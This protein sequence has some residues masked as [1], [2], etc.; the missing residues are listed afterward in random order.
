MSNLTNNQNRV[1]L[2]LELYSKGRKIRSLSKE[3]NHD[4]VLKIFILSRLNKRTM[5]ISQLSEEIY[6]KLST[7]SETIELLHKEGLIEKECCDDKR[8]QTIKLTHKGTQYLNE[9][10]SEMQ[11]HC[12]GIF[13]ELDDKEINILLETIRKI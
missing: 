3:G 5:N 8:E 6:S 10:L 11:K 2:L 12:T 1:E 13:S 4:Q 9:T 7:V